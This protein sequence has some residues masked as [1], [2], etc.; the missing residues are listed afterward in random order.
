MK[1]D[2]SGI[3]IH[4]RE[5]LSDFALYEESHYVGI[6]V[7]D[8]V[9]IVYAPFDRLWKNRDKNRF[10]LQ[11]EPEVCYILHFGIEEKS[12]REGHGTKLIE[13]ITDF[14]SSEFGVSRFVTT[15]SG[16]SKENSFYESCGFKYFNSNEVEK[17]V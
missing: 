9:A 1:Y 11:V 16:M 8:V 5:S 10:S 15:P 6:K 4:L 17:V 7:K 14:V 2:E 13:L 12:R 3:E